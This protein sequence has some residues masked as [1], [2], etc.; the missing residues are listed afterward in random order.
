MGAATI[1]IVEDDSAVAELI[2][3]LLADRGYDI[4]GIVSCGDKA[5][6]AT[7]KTSPDLV[8]MNIKLKGK[9]DGITAFEK[10]RKVVDVP[11]IFVSGYADREMVD[12]A[13]QCNPSGYIVKPFKG[14]ELL[15][16]VESV[17]DWHRILSE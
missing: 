6:D 10:I 17:L 15:R 9:I 2:E 11:V 8:L 3:L 14:E 13:M 12:R 5:I 4:C 16:K 7:I 1:L